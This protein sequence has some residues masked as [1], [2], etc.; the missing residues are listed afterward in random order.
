MG[1]FDEQIRT[2]KQRDDDVFSDSFINMA[3]AVLGEKVRAALNDDK[4]VAVTAMEQILKFYHV[5]QREIPENVQDRNEQLEYLMRPSGIMRRYVSLSRGWRKDAFGAMLAVRTDTEGLTALIPDKFN[6]YRFLDSE[7]GKWVRVDAKNEELFMGEVI[8]FYKPLPM[9]KLTIPDLMLYMLQT[10]NVGDLAALGVG[11]AL[12]TLV[13]LLVPKLNALIFSSVVLKGSM[14][15]FLAV[16][17]FMISVTLSRLFFNSVVS[18]LQNRIHTK[19]STTVEAA[20]M[21]R[22]LSLP[23]GFFRKYSSGELSSRVQQLSALCDSL[24][25]AVLSTGLTGVFSLAYISQIFRYAPALVVPALLII[26]ATVTFTL[27]TAVVETRESKAMMELAAKE[28]GLSYAFISG[29]QKIRLA[30]AEKRVFAKWANQYAQFARYEYAPHFVIRYNGVISTGIMLIGN[31]I[32][33]ICAFQ[34]GISVEHYYAFNSAYGMIS[35][36]FM[37]LAGLS[38]TFATVK[39]TLEMVRPLLECEPEITGEKEVLTR[40]NGG[41]ELNNVTFRYDE[42]SPAV[43]EN[44]SLKIRPGQYVAIVGKTGCG[45]STLMRLLLGFETPQKGAVYYDGKDLNKLDLKSLRRRIGAVTQDG[46]LFSGDIYSNITISAPWLNLHDAWEAAEIAGMAE[47]IRK[48]PM[49]MQTVISEGSGGISGG[50][51]QRLMIARAV[52]PKPRIL[53]FDEATSALDNITQKKVSEALDGMKCTRIV[54]AHRLSTIRHCDRILVLDGG[55]IVEDGTY[56]ELI[57]RGGFFSEL[58]ARQ[59]VDA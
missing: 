29:I 16:T 22:V 41:I 35:G 17:V 37:A 32:M 18:L 19:L 15:L 25:N 39:P 57:E 31:L 51:R 5:K 47:D 28:N 33:Y 14:R 36:A 6:R 49:G 40:L 46:K 13:G 54:I 3:G 10:L 56:D 48:M 58:V 52:A 23:A 26:L 12:S 42:N 38:M 55:H 4:T 24:V 8:A 45:K 1:W 30:G 7:T 59:R 50:Q 2:R 44:L 9:K 20:A 43:V 21:M 53:M 27:V 11:T 34:S